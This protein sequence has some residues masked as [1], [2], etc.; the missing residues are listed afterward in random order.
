MS[1]H[2]T[3]RYGGS[4]E[5]RV[6]LSIEVVTALRNVMPAEMPLFV[7]ISSTDWMEGGWDLPQSIELA[8][9][10]K[11]LGVDLMDCSSG[12]LIKT[13]KVPFAPG[14][15]VP[16]AAAIRKEAGILTSA[17]G[18]ITDP[19]QANEIVTSGSAD[20]TFLAREMLREPYW[21]LKAQQALGETPS[22]P[23]QYGYVVKK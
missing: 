6:R 4:L 15:Q 5:N 10:L 13:A 3:D 1:N 7:R 22:W 9:H 16:F 17:V 23:F 12:A 19:N 14:F 18:M 8:R 21:A 20:L 11:P 2:R